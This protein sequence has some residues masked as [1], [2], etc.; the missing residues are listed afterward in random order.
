MIEE[1][2]KNEREGGCWQ[3]NRNPAN[4]PERTVPKCCP[5]FYDAS[6]EERKEGKRER[7]KKGE[8]KRVQ[9]EEKFDRQVR[10]D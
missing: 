10:G 8:R 5:F 4:N 9:K 7:K 1:R 2:V 6:Q 3:E